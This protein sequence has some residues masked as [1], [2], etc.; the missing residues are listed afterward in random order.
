MKKISD[1]VFDESQ[2]A[3]GLNN[4]YHK[5]GFLC[6]GVQKHFVSENSFD[7]CELFG[8]SIHEPFVQVRHDGSRRSS[9]LQVVCWCDS[10]HESIVSILSR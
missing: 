1:A 3:T 5:L 9:R 2:I 4:N 6:L 10:V 7:P 8:S